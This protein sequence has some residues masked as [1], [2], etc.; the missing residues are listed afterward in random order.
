MKCGNNCVQLRPI[1]V[2]Y[3]P[4]SADDGQGETEQQIDV[5]AYRCCFVNWGLQRA[6]LALNT[7]RHEEERGKSHLTY[8]VALMF[9]WS[10]I[11]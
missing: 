6:L 11:D 5:T 2:Y 7:E 9:K 4:L 10:M 8:C 1:N 3:S